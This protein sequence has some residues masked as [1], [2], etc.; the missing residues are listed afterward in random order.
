M[1]SRT[2]LRNG[3]VVVDLTDD[4]VETITRALAAFASQALAD[5]TAA[6]DLGE[7][8]LADA[9]LFSSTQY[10]DLSD[11]LG[12]ADTVIWPVDDDD[13]D[14]RQRPPY[15]DEFVEDEHLHGTR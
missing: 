3:A 8:G 14:A 11:L 2:Q 5:A 15:Q 4:D 9:L 12:E 10:R 7:K 6:N 13:L 1:A